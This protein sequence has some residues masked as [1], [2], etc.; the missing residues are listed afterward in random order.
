MILDKGKCKV[1]AGEYF[2]NISLAVFVGGVIGGAFG[3]KFDLT[4]VS[5]GL[6]LS[7]IIF[8]FGLL[9]KGGK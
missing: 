3:Q 1:I 5:V 4:S 6:I 8:V 9:M 7:L 2:I